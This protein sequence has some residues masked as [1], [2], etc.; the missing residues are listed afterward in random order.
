[1]QESQAQL[2]HLLP[3]D[4]ET[5]AVARLLT[6]K[7]HTFLLDSRSALELLKAVVRDA[8]P[9]SDAAGEA[10]AALAAIAS[11]DYPEKADADGC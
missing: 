1:M 11:E 8:Q 6:A 5:V 2:E 4:D 9:G 7:A 10:L 3:S